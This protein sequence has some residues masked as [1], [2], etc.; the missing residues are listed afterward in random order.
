MC[1]G[2]GCGLRFF[3]LVTGKAGAL[4]EPALCWALKCGGEQK[5]ELIRTT[6]TITETHFRNT[7]WERHKVGVL[8]EE[9][10]REVF[11]LSCESLEL[12]PGPEKKCFW[13]LCMAHGGT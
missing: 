3:D 6:H 13:Q 11:D 7:A 12:L 9:P 5:L 4:R 8:G 2:G 10:P 1:W